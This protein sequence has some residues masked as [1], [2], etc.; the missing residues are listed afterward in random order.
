MKISANLLVLRRPKEI[1]LDKRKI[2]QN[3]DNWISF[4]LS[5]FS[6][7]QGKVQHHRTV[8][9]KMS[10]QVDAIDSEKMDQ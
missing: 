6:P 3:F 5:T 7:Q 1:A 2:M 10:R 4:T 8:R 9:S